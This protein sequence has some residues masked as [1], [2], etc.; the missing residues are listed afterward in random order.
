MPIV[1]Q[2]SRQRSFHTY[3][4]AHRFSGQ[5]PFPLTVRRGRQTVISNGRRECQSRISTFPRSTGLDPSRANTD[6]SLAQ[7]LISAENRLPPA[8]DQ[9]RCS[10]NLYILRIQCPIENSNH[11]R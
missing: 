4:D 11:A 2:L 1:E 3:K 9:E 6:C 5:A 7:P 8:V 10:P